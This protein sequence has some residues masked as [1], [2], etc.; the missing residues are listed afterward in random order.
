[1]NDSKNINNQYQ[2]SSGG[3]GDM[4]FRRI[5]GGRSDAFTIRAQLLF[6]VVVLWL[7]LVLLTLY[8]GTFTAGTTTRP[9]IYDLVPHVRFLIALPLL[10]LADLAIDPTF[11]VA[12]RNLQCSGVVPREHENLL[13]A[14]LDKLQKARDALSPDII[15]LIL[16]VAISWIFQPGYGYD[17]LQVEEGSW[18]LGIDD[19]G[20]QLTGAGN[21][22]VF[23]TAPLFQFVLFRW[24]WRFLIWA[25]FLYRLSRIP[26]AL[27]STH[28]DLAGGLGTLGMM[29][30]TF[31]IVFVAFSTVMSSTIAHNI[32]FEGD[33]L[34]GSVVDII[35]FI[36]TCVVLVYAPLLFLVKGMYIARRTG[37]SRYGALGYRLSAAF[38]KKWITGFSAG[39]GE[40]LKDSTDSSTMAD[41]AATFDTVFGM[42]L[43]PLSSRAVM[44]TAAALLIP[45]LPLVL[46]EFSVQDLLQRVIDSLV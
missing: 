45:F 26:L 40:E 20:L 1:M 41:Y 34:Q 29:Q 9:F 37:L 42:R 32:L 38:D 12:I 30:Q 11:A 4:L 23:V 21:W 5:R 17:G 25:V 13:Q 7:P 43:L 28:P 33:T 44:M 15:L 14:A 24:F 19:D 31:T 46:T 16:A 18:L 36:G 2:L 22:Y 10:L 6:V 27:Q 3:L 35:V 8:E 39:V